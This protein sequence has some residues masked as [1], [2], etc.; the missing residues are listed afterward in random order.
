VFDARKVSNYTYNHSTSKP[1]PLLIPLIKFSTK[2]GECV[3]DPYGGSGST[4]E[5]CIQLKRTFVT[6][7]IDPEWYQTMNNRYNALTRHNTI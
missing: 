2:E 5:A 3:V 1:V 4:M 6:T 7:D